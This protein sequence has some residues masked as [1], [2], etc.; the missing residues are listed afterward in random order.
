MKEE[1]FFKSV[2]AFNTNHGLELA[3]IDEFRTITSSKNDDEQ[4]LNIDFYK[5]II[6]ICSYQIKSITEDKNLKNGYFN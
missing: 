5:A 6:S 2:K 1:T 4:I 3:I